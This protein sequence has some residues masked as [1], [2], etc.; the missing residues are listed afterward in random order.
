MT[1]WRWL[2]IILLAVILVFEFVAIFNDETGDTISENIWALLSLSWLL[3]LLM[4]AVL[5]WLSVHFLLP[6][7]RDWWRRR[8]WET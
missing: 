4:G 6:R 8:P 2:W 5:L 3:W 7:V 1:R